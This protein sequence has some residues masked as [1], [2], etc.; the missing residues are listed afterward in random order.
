MIPKYFAD[1]LPRARVFQLR[2]TAISARAPAIWVRMYPRWS[3]PGRGS[4]AAQGGLR[5]D[6]ARRRHPALKEKASSPSGLS[7]AQ[8]IE[9]ACELLP[10]PST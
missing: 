9:T 5:D 10:E 2:P 6:H 1:S 7:P 3:S 8:L 4:P